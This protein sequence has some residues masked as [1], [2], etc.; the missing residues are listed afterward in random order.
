NSKRG[1]A[2]MGS[3]MPRDT[4]NPAATSQPTAMVCP[5]CGPGA[6]FPFSPYIVLG[7]TSKSS[8]CVMYLT[9]DRVD[10]IWVLLALRSPLMIGLQ[11]TTCKLCPGL[12]RCLKE[13]AL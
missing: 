10:I 12:G 3:R 6:A 8:C 13:F 9:E 2:W 1:A 7:S 11:S 4:Q 5:S